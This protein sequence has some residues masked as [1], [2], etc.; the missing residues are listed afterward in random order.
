[1]DS[2]AD[3]I[4]AA[5]TPPGTG[6][7]GVVRVSG[8]DVEQIARTMLG[9]LPEP[10][11]ATY[12]SFRNEAGER[13]DAGLALYFPAPASFTGESVLELHGHGGPVVVSLL[14]DAVV[15]LGA[16]QAQPGEFSKRAFLNGK[17]DLVQ[18]EAIA[19][20]IASGTAQAARAALRS[21]AG[22]FSAAINALAEQLVRLRMHV[23][24]AIDFPE[25]EIDF[26]SDDALLARIDECAEAFGTLVSEARQG[27][28]LRDGFQV[29]IVGK[30]NAGKSSLLNLLSGQEAAIVTEIAGTTRDVLREQID[31]D[32]LAVDIVDTAGLRDDPDLIEAEGIR[33]AKEALGNADAVLWIQDVTGAGPDR[34]DM[35]D[36]APVTIVHNKIDKSGDEPGLRDG[37]VWISA[38]TGAGVDALRRRIREL[39]GYENLGEGAFTARR[40]HV[41][42][43]RRAHEHFLAGRKALDERRSGELMAE[44][45]RL[46]HDALGEITGASTADDLLGRIF[47]KF[48]IGK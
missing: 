16:R 22:R 29:V 17:L 6:G 1:M 9:S 45:L 12:R 24:A 8:D 5:A 10:R 48:C 42:A 13:I 34:P 37:E 46:A 14:V 43:L 47:S 3:T 20:L 25:E 18:A 41:R 38:Q 15:E 23:E 31:V 7:V 33:R 30:P 4:V 21:L 11:T 35:P 32:G 36:G 26:L 39:A 19:D 27:R 28:V 44:E 2:T 40:R